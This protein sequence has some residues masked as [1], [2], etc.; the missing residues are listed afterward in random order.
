MG[1]NSAHDGYTYQDLLISYFILNDILDGNRKSIYSID[2]KHT[3]GRYVSVEKDKSGKFKEKSVPDRFDDFVIFNESFTKRMQIK[4]SNEDNNRNFIKSDFA[5]DKKGLGLYELYRTWLEL[6]NNTEEFRLC[7]A[8]NKPIDV[9]II[10]V[11]K[12]TREKSSFNSFITTRYKIDI[13]KLWEFNSLP[14]SNWVNL[15]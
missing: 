15:R 14:S 3:V 2:K 8:W 10:S 1:L 4:Y 6:K 7:L 11:L 13:D 12:S 9:D 5:N